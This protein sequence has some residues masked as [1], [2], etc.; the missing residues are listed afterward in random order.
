MD[1]ELDPVR[2]AEVQEH[3]AQCRDCSELFARVQ[4]QRSEIRAM[5]AYAAPPALHRLLR[6]AV[7]R[8]AGQQQPTGRAPWRSLA[9]AASV[10]LCVS[11][12]WN[13]AGLRQRAGSG[14]ALA[15][16]ILSSHVRSL[17]GSH[18]LDVPSSDQHTVKPWFNGKLD[19]S[20]QVKDLADQGFPLA[21]GRLE[22][23]GGRSVAALIFRR[24]QHVVNLY[25]WPSA[26]DKDTKFSQ[27]GYN[28][29]HWSDAGMSYWA[30]SDIPLNEL[31]QFREAYQK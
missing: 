28:M 6:E 11:L 16:D 29:L 13:V 9:I 7:R 20:P 1:E 17:I 18:L 5:A 10:L 15:E 26:P 30:A 24:R 3:L 21:G 19:F 4:Q 31:Q 27:Q 2:D 25:T 14:D 22:Y 23:A 12:G 8:E